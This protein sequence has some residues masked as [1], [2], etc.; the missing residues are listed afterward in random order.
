MLMTMV[1][2]ITLSD[3]ESMT[4]L[5]PKTNIMVVAA[6]CFA[7]SSVLLAGYAFWGI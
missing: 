2:K 7:K 5:T 6:L 1:V 4:N 3:V